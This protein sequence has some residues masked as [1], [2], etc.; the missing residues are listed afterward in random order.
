MNW[1]LGTTLISRNFNEE[2]NTTP[3]FWNHVAIWI[4]NGRIVESQRGKGV[5]LTALDDWQARPILWRPLIPRPQ[6][7]ERGI[8][9]ANTACTLVGRPWG[10]LSSVRR[11]IRSRL[12]CVSVWELSWEVNVSWPDDIAE[13]KLFKL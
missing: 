4:G 12:S 5:I 7:F 10:P 2:D 3:G 11:K 8:Q 9:A 6:F 1:P 13:L